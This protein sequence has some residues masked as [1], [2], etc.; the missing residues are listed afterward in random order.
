MEATL[1][2]A[3]TTLLTCAFRVLTLLRIA[4]PVPTPLPDRLAAIP[5]GSLD[6]DNG[7]YDDD[8]FDWWS[9]SCGLHHLNPVRVAYFLQ[10]LDEAAAAAAGGNGGAKGEGEGEGDRVG[11]GKVQGEK[12]RRRSGG[13]GGGGEKEDDEKED[14]EEERYEVIGLDPSQRS[15][16]VARSHAAAA[17]ATTAASGPGPLR[18]RY[19]VGS[20]YSLPLA[21]SSID[22][23]IC[24]DVLEHLYNL[25]LALSE[26]ARVLKPGG[27]V[28]FDTINRTPLSYYL[29][30]WV[31]QDVLRAMQADAHDHRMYVTPCEMRTGLVAAGLEPGPQRDLVGIR[32]SLHWPHVTLWRLLTG[33]AGFMSAVLTRFQL[34]SSL[35]ISYLYCARKPL[36]QDEGARGP[37]R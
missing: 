13:G 9:D 32:P 14:D 30:I 11:R 6:I 31:L 4:P 26:M 2:H 22:A 1:T 16:D 3:A 8:S 35:D 21:T 37:G 12:R 10:K 24:S 34:T 7:I 29:S 27:V 28:T 23:I 20:V 19:E 36:R 15:I 17:T 18:I 5:E 33:R 25:P